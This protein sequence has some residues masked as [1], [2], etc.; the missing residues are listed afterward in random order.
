MYPVT[1][2]TFASSNTSKKLKLRD[3]KP[4]MTSSTV[5]LLDAN[6]DTLTFQVEQ[7]SS[8]LH[9]VKKL[10]RSSTRKALLKLKNNILTSTII[11]K[12]SMRNI[13]NLSAIRENQAIETYM[14]N[15]QMI[16]LVDWDKLNCPVRY[17]P[18]MRVK[19]IDRL[20]MSMSDFGSTAMETCVTSYGD[21]KLWIV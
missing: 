8:T 15:C 9:R 21:Y 10:R 18:E 4:K 13:S 16:S 17:A 3:I 1:N 6:T 14:K 2:S 11:E 7:T 12:E 20:E 5:S 19:D